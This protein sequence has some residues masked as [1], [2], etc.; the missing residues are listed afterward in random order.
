MRLLTRR[1]KA[2]LYIQANL[3]ISAVDCQSRLNHSNSAQS[4]LNQDVADVCEACVF[5]FCSGQS[6][7]SNAGNDMNILY[8]SVSDIFYF[9]MDLFCPHTM[10][11]PPYNR[12]TA[13]P[14]MV[15]VSPHS[16]ARR[17][18]TWIAISNLLI[19]TAFSTLSFLLTFLDNLQFAIH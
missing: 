13:Y 18:G 4:Q 3:P 7:F 5:K 11:Q 17:L 15:T 19:P 14:G 12:H 2:S 1:F 8:F 6:T 16:R 10:I 9:C